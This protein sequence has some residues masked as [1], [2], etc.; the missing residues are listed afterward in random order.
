[1]VAHA[2]V[3][4]A[5]TI[6]TLPGRTNHARIRTAKRTSAIATSIVC[7]GPYRMP[8][9]FLGL[10]ASQTDAYEPLPLHLIR[11]LSMQTPVESFPLF[12]SRDPQAHGY[13]QEL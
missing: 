10:N 11:G 2:G 5:V 8:L 7:R 4:W 13:V 1:M 6:V 9:S 12:L 3:S